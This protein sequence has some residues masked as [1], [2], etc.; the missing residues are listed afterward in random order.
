LLNILRIILAPATILFAIL[1]KIRNWLFDRDIFTAEKVESKVISIGNLTLGGSGKTPAVIAV[2]NI[3]K[4]AGVAV[5]LLSRGYGRRSKGYLLVSRGEGDIIPVDECSDEM[6]LVT[7][8]CSVPS[9]VSERRASGAKNLLN[10]VPL[11][12]IV[13]DDAFQHRWI[14]RDLDIVMCDQ[15]FLLKTGKMDQNLLPLGVMREPFSS[16]NRADIIILNRKFTGKKDIPQKIQKFLKNKKVYDG[17]YE[18][19]GIYDLKTHQ[20]SNMEEFRGQNSLV[21]CGI[22]RPY[23]FLNVVEKSGINIKNKMLFPDHKDYTLKEV[24]SIRKRFYD[25]NSFSV[26]ATQ[27]DAVKLTNFARELDDIDIYYLK[28]ELKIEN[29]DSFI[30]EVLSVTNN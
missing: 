9:A 3:L 22:A 20:E 23:S 8:E 21:V 19:S 2:I 17:H 18:V 10:D 7:D 1:V 14:A 13:L 12:V 28:I 15:R 24:Q 30:K 6:Y 27:K 26:L 5:G 29:E 11:D 4:N 25:T 16:L